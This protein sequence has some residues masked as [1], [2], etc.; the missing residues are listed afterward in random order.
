[1]PVVERGKALKRKMIIKVITCIMMLVLIATTSVVPVMASP[2]TTTVNVHYVVADTSLKNFY[3]NPDN[4]F[5]GSNI[6]EEINQVVKCQNKWEQEFLYPNIKN[7]TISIYEPEEYIKK[8]AKESKYNISQETVDKLIAK[9]KSYNYSFTTPYGKKFAYEERTYGGSH[10]YSDGYKDG[11][12]WNFK[13]NFTIIGSLVDDYTDY[14]NND[15]IKGKIQW[16]TNGYILNADKEEMTIYVLMTPCTANVNF[17][18]NTVYSN[19]FGKNTDWSQ[20]KTKE[21]VENIIKNQSQYCDN[22]DKYFQYRY[23]HNSHY[24]QTG[25]T[26]IDLRAYVDVFEDIEYPL[27]NY[28]NYKFFSATTETDEN[29]DVKN[30]ANNNVINYMPLAFTTFYNSRYSPDIF[31][32][33]KNVSSH[34]IK[35]EDT[36]GNA[37]PFNLKGLKYSNNMAAHYPDSADHTKYISLKT[38]DNPYATEFTDDYFVTEIKWNNE[39]SLIEYINNEDV[40]KKENIKNDNDFSTVNNN[41]YDVLLEKS[42]L[43]NVDGYRLKYINQNDADTEYTIINKNDNEYYYN[44]NTPYSLTDT[45]TNVIYEKSVNL[46]VNYID[47]KGKELAPSATEQGW[48]SEA[49]TTSAIDVKGYELTETPSNA[50]GVYTTQDTVVNYIY[51]KVPDVVVQKPEQPTPSPPNKT[52]ETI[53]KTEE[54]E[55]ID[56]GDEIQHYIVIGAILLLVLI[57]SLGIIISKIKKNNC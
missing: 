46:T 29:I 23:C 3:T 5:E 50:N 10:Q 42:I 27:L 18:D 45:T 15:Y 7:G 38:D 54:V 43:N 30:N 20:I 12:V 8:K 41:S 40:L 2:N 39:L 11:E 44:G 28:S 35:F 32:N 31:V 9:T 56:T 47:E 33:Y 19:N 57:A 22:F 48:S 24:N 55:V 13:D 1:M 21:E 34:S 53:T 6:A 4:Y 36:D 16:G 49:Y 52:E 26:I 37:V 25:H 14:N 17:F 51:K